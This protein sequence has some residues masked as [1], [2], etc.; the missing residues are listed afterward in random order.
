M[1]KKKVDLGVAA[2]GAGKAA[3]DLLNKAKKTVASAVDQNDDGTFDLK[4]VSAM[5]ENISAAAKKAVASV[6]DSADARAQEQ[7]RKTLGPIFEDDL[8]GADFFMPKLIRITDMDRKHAESEVCR[9]SIGY[10]STQKELTIVNI[11]KDKAELFGLTF[12]PDMEREIY[13]V[14]P[15]DRNQY[16]ALDDYFESLKVARINELQKIA[17]DLGARHFKVTYKEQQTAHVA[18]NGKGAGHVKGPVKAAAAV[19]VK[20]ESS[21]SSS[22]SVEIAA[23]M[24]CPGHAPKKPQL[25]YL[26]KEKSIQSLI[27]LRMDKESPL[28]H[29]KYTLKLS[30]SSGI[31]EGD[32]MK[33]DSA[34]KSMKCAGHISVTSEARKEAHRFFEYEIDF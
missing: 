15:V 13:Y 1:E 7:E 16:I 8:V 4:D 34:L 12:F 28:T 31:R 14:D 23:E 11:Y 25:V 21:E 19:D 22:F 20:H 18:K 26:Q 30:N 29:Q 10:K 2:V 6:K 9:G 24:T 33:I 3:A 17:Q 5:A 27:D 32:A